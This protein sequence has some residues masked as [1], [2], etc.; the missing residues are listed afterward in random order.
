[1]LRCA[2]W[3]KYM[4]VMLCRS[5]S[6]RDGRNRYRSQSLVSIEIKLKAFLDRDVL[7][8]TPFPYFTFAL[9]KSPQL[10][11]KRIFLFSSLFRSRFSPF[12]VNE[13]DIMYNILRHEVQCHIDGGR[14]LN[15]YWRLNRFFP[16]TCES[17]PT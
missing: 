3:G 16:L 1:M 11:V 17:V 7:H 6:A 5:P 4:F 12:H 2:R 8:S 14:Q 10:K 15:M 13:T 9:E